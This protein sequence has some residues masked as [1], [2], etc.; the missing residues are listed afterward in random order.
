M[1]DFH[2]HAPE[3]TFVHNKDNTCVSISLDYALFAENKHVVEHEEHAVFH[4][5]HHLYHGT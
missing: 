3:I 1:H 5:F 2:P 4:D